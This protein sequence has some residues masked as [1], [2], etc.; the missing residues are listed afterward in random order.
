[1]SFVDRIFIDQ[2]TIGDSLVYWRRVLFARIFGMLAIICIPVY[3]TSV[4]LCI[5]ADLLAMAV[6]DTLV[7]AIL[8]FIIF[9]KKITDSNRYK[10]GCLLAFSIGVGFLVAIG[11]SGAGF[12]WLFMFPPLTCILLGKKASN[13]AQFLNAISLVLLGVAY[14][15]QFHIW[16]NIEGYSLIIWTVVVINFLATNAI[17]TVST[18]F[19]IGK[20]SHSLD[21]TLTSR[22]ATVI[23][24]AKLAEYRDNE[25]GAHLLRMQRYAGLL[26][27]QRLTELD[28]PEELTPAFIEEI[29]LSSVLHDIG[30]VGIADAILL[31][32]GKLT[33]EEFENIKAHPV[34]GSSVLDSLT[35]YAPDCNFIKM[36]R[37]I[38]GGHHEKWDG[39]GYPK[40]LSGEDIPLA[41]RIV[42][43]VDVYDALTSP[44]CYK[45]PFSHDKAVTLILEGKGKHFDPNLVESFIK[46]DHLFERLSLQSLEEEDAGFIPA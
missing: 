9:D 6:F 21:S 34:I 14:H 30:K 40:G 31:K 25:T 35:E 46:I 19:L 16:P 33:P 22:R 41:A 36:G 27:K 38:A 5:Q 37:D 18:S 44:R 11:P 26:A 7:Y 23:G 10:I 29:T 13:V 20:L 2:V 1:M 8:L 24:L 43:L 4:Y 32:P 45:Q 17:V 15:F 28:A 42:A 12:F 3:V 39:T